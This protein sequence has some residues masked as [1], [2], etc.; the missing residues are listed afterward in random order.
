MKYHIECYVVDDLGRAFTNAILE[1][2]SEL[3]RED[4]VKDTRLALSK[5]FNVKPSQIYVEELTVKRLKKE[6][7]L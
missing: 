3:N 5:E 6:V 1:K 7:E 2:E 4:F